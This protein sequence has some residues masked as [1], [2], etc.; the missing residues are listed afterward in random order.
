MSAIPKVSP[1]EYE[2]LAV[3]A[4]NEELHP[5]QIVDASTAVKRGS[6]YAYLDRLEKKKW[7]SSAAAGVQQFSGQPIRRY[8]ITGVG[9]ARYRAVGPQDG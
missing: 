5:L 2:I 6:I 7:V 8:R 9:R 1:L 3:L 4:A